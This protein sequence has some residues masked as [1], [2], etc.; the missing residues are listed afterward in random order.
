MNIILSIS[1]LAL[2]YNGKQIVDNFSLSIGSGEKVLLAGP[3]G[4]GK[5]SILKA[6][7]GFVK[8]VK[9]EIRIVDTVLDETS[10]WEARK[11][12]AYVPQNCELTPGT[13]GEYCREL[14]AF[15]ANRTK[16]FDEATMVSTA[17][18]FGLDRE[19]LAKPFPELSGGERQRAVL[20]AALMLARPFIILD[21]PTSALDTDLKIVVADAILSDPA[22]TALIVSHDS[23][24]SRATRQVSL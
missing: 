1:N 12:I 2:A 3:S 17:G 9:G 5:S 7:L 8:Q 10:V 19:K 21:E 22:L 15:R 20:V 4:R 6:I 24:W 16:V 11:S 14:F 18:R 23:E 13:L